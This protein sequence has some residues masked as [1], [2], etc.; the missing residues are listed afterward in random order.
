MTASRAV[1]TLANGSA[2]DLF[3]RDLLASLHLHL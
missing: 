1:K 3:F 2:V